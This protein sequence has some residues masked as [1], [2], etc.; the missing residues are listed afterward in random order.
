VVDA[1]LFSFIAAAAL[2]AI[3]YFLPVL[4]PFFAPS[5]GALAHKA[6]FF[7]QILFLYGAGHANFSGVF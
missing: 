3:F 1:S 7:G 2:G 5:E 4:F 6:V